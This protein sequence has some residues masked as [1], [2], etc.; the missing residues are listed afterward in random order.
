[1]LQVEAI[2]FFEKMDDFYIVS[3]N[4][5]FGFP[6]GSWTCITVVFIVINHKQRFVTDYQAYTWQPAGCKLFL[7]IPFDLVLQ[8]ATLTTSTIP[9]TFSSVF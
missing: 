9:Q 2:L 1:M 6:A 7:I 3:D 5:W 4:R 8:L